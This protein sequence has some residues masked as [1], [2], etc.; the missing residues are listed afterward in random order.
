M[1]QQPYA[2]PENGQQ[3]QLM[4]LIILISNQ[5]ILYQLELIKLIIM[6][7]CRLT[8]AEI[9]EVIVGTEADRLGHLMYQLKR[10]LPVNLE[11]HSYQ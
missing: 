11:T 5:L 2:L 10:R 9:D 1:N 3:D 6:I 7:I 8:T 4:H